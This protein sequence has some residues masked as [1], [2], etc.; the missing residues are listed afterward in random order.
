MTRIAW[1]VR[2]SSTDKIDFEV[3][4]SHAIRVIRGSVLD[5]DDHSEFVINWA[6]EVNYDKAYN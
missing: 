3:G 2:R 4:A 1:M 5:F 6:A